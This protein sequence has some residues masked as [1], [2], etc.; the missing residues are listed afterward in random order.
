MARNFAV[1][2]ASAVILIGSFCAGTNPAPQGEFE[3]DLNHPT[4]SG[5]ST[6]MQL[7]SEFTT[8]HVALKVRV[9]WRRFCKLIEHWRRQHQLTGACLPKGN[10]AAPHQRGGSCQGFYFL[11]KF[12]P[13]L[14]VVPDDTYLLHSLTLLF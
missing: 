4:Q 8:L 5:N 1:S 2:R 9:L 14:S 12:L 13:L 6:L 10:V 7:V 11:P 3:D